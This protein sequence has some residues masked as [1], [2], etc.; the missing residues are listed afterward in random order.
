MPQI[1][2]TRPCLPNLPALGAAALIGALAGPA[3]AQF[4]SSDRT[5]ANGNPLNGTYY[6]QTVWV[7]VSGVSNGVVTRVAN[8]QVDVVEP[9][10]F[11]YSD[12]TGGGLAA[13]SNS[14]VRMAGGTFAQH[15]A[16]GFG[17]YVSLNDTS[18]AV[19]DGGSL[20]G[21]STAGAA[22]GAAGS[23]VT[24]N[25]GVVQNGIG[26]IAYILNG[27]LVVNGG[28]LRAQGGNSAIAGGA[29]AVVDVNGGL[30]QSVAGS[31][32]Y[33]DSDSAFT[34]S[35]GTVRG[36]PGGGAQWGVRLQS[37]TTPAALRGG[38]VDGGLRADA[39]NSVLSPQAVLGGNLALNGGVFAYGNAALDVTGGLYTRFAGADASFFALGSNTINFFGT[40]LALSAP[41]AGQVFETNNY[42]GNFY[43]FTN[44]TFADGQ[45]AIGLRVFDADAVAGNPLGG[46]FTL[47]AAPVPEPGTGLLLLMA[48][49]ALGGAIR[50][51]QGAR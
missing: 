14:V 25:G 13:Y 37:V 12:Q 31:A 49:P 20:R 43:T 28:T 39:L 23:Q 34:M 30:V 5:V 41:T 4:I 24:L 19:I 46:G 45:S 32:V 17:G 40:D 2:R 48:L 3:S 15:S 21:L 27:R 6:G 18:T 9:A 26:G 22:P 11:S 44:G 8:V 47:N 51:R 16:N 7:G 10:L 1:R 29:G 35:G 50:R 42:S 36:G 33:L 38:T